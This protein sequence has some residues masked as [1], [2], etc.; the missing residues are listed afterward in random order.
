M[1]EKEFVLATRAIINT[2]RAEP[3]FRQTSVRELLSDERLGPINEE[4]RREA[5]L[6]LMKEQILYLSSNFKLSLNRGTLE[7]STE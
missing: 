7:R 6:T 5:M 2:L 4:I 1:D 3:P